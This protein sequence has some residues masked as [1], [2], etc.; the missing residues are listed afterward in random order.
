MMTALPSPAPGNPPANLEDYLYVSQQANDQVGI[1]INI[2]GV[3]TDPDGLVVIV[4]MM[5]DLA[6]VQPIFTG[7]NAVRQ[8]TGAY[9]YTFLSAD[10]QITG[11]Y[12]LAWSYQ[13]SGVPDTYLTPI[14]VGSYSPAYDALGSDMQAIIELVW[15]KFADIYDSQFGGPNLQSYFQ[16]HFGRGRMAQLLQVTMMTINLSMQPV[17]NYSLTGPSSDPNA[18]ITGP[19]FPT[20]AYGG[21]LVQGLTIEVIK[22]LMRS[23]VEEPLA[24]GSNVQARLTRRDYLQRWG[25]MLQTEQSAYE[26]ELEVFKIR[27]MFLLQ[28]R[29]LV[30]GGVYGNFGPTRLA[31]NAAARPRYWT[32]WY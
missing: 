21:L 14:E 10:T 3:P 13:L 18:P 19:A 17:N 31:G 9:T 2:G 22:H 16:S 7:R 27:Q 5:P 29:V 32:R 6:G 12:H 28:P 30:S 23:Y 25:E 4:S 24:E 20:Q 8:Y 26:R 15:A 1:I 11:H